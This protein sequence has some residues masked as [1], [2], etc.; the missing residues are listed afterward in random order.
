MTIREDHKR[1]WVWVREYRERDCSTAGCNEIIK[2]ISWVHPKPREDYISATDQKEDFRP[3]FRRC[4]LCGAAAYQRECDSV[5]G[6]TKLYP[7]FESLAPTIQGLLRAKAEREKFP[8]HEGGARPDG[9]PWRLDGAP[10][11][12]HPCAI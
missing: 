6:L 9:Q 8:V 12:P 3:V 2:R 5:L 10:R 11:G 4:Y 7:R 1:V